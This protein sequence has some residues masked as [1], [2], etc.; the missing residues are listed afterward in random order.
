MAVKK[1]AAKPAAKK[2]A[3][4]PKADIKAPGFS[5]EAKEKTPNQGRGVYRK[6]ST[7]SVIAKGNKKARGAKEAASA[8]KEYGARSVDFGGKKGIVA[9]GVSLTELAAEDIAALN[10]EAEADAGKGKA[11]ALE[12]AEKAGVRIKPSASKAA[13]NEAQKNIDNWAKQA[14]AKKKALDTELAAP[15]KRTEA[16]EAQRA[17]LNSAVRGA[18]ADPTKKERIFNKVSQVNYG[19]NHHMPCTTE[20]CRNVVPAAFGDSACP[21]CSAQDDAK[22]DAAARRAGLPGASATMTG[23]ERMAKDLKAKFS[24]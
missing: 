23:V 10:K 3:A 18:G 7:A 19:A 9:A 5:L 12:D 22:F 4:K 1:A 2:T 21:T 16:T 8:L 17:Q 6:G 13:E 11:A 24:N 20:G 14:E 15:F